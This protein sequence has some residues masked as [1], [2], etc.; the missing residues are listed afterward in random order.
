MKM[1]KDN[2]ICPFFTG[3]KFASFNQELDKDDKKAEASV[4]PS[5]VNC[6]EARCHMWDDDAP[7]PDCSIK[8]EHMAARAYYE[9]NT[10]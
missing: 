7:I 5:S 1:A 2:D 8:L 3:G 10:P 9:A 6:R 4:S